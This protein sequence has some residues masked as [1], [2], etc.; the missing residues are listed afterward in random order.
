[1]WLDK[2]LYTDRSDIP[3]ASWIFDEDE[4]FSAIILATSIFSPVHRW[5]VCISILI[6]FDSSSWIVPVLRQIYD[7]R[8]IYWF[9]RQK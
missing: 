4:P 3:T 7:K 9:N 6:A 5:E 2:N 8:Q 1:M